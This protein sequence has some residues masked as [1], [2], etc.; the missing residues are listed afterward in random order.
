MRVNATLNPFSAN[1]IIFFRA[2]FV[3]E[4]KMTYLIAVNMLSIS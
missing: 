4:W 2:K 1:S 3:H